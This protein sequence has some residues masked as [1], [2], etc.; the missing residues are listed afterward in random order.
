MVFNDSNN[1]YKLATILEKQMFEETSEADIEYLPSGADRIKSMLKSLSLMK[2]YWGIEILENCFGKTVFIENK[3]KITVLSE[4]WDSF[5]SL[6]PVELKTGQI[7]FQSYLNESM[8]EDIEELRKELKPELIRLFTTPPFDDVEKDLNIFRSFFGLRSHLQQKTVISYSDKEK[9]IKALSFKLLQKYGEDK[10]GLEVLL[11]DIK[12]RKML[13]NYVG[14]KSENYLYGGRIL[15][16]YKG[17]KMV[18]EMTIDFSYKVSS[19]LTI[20]D[21]DI[22]NKLAEESTSVK[23]VK[24]VV[25]PVGTRF[26]REVFKILKD[27]LGDRY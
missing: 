11:E 15:S 24:N 25:Y 19:S 17:T 9:T 20:N 27:I 6:F 13:S 5:K 21:V 1:L 12:G 23:A 2:Q 3:A 7:N 18:L 22:A 8:E 14:L 26:Q 16:E 4:H 10:G